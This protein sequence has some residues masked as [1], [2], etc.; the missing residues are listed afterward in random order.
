M[1]DRYPLKF[2]PFS[3]HS[4]II[5]LAGEG[6]RRR[7][8]DIGCAD[9]SLGWTLSQKD[10]VVTGIEPDPD[11]AERARRRGM[12]V[13]QGTLEEALPEVQGNY[14]LVVLGDVL[15][16]VVDPWGS[17]CQIVSGLNPGA[18]I[19]I[20]LPN[21]AHLFVRLQLLIGRFEYSDRGLLDRT[22]LRFFTR[23]TAL[24][25]VNGAGLRIRSLNVTSTPI[26]ILFPRLLD[27]AS[28][29]LFLR[30]NQTIAN[31]LP[32]VFAY[33]FIVECVVTS[34]RDANLP[35]DLR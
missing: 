9:G 17:L 19:I 11:D 7:A 2:S 16:H 23:R 27:H 22:H 29:R 26:E 6:D 31:L 21:V 32:R 33:Q 10:W 1:S 15:E 4:K 28:G 3:S 30:A 5:A 8:L 34:S 18:R 14:S 25:L 35:N 20:S 24:E 13:Y 12:D